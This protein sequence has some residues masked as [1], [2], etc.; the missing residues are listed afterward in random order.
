LTILAV[1]GM[2]ELSS[3]DL[4]CFLGMGKV[5]AREWEKKEKT[6]SS[7]QNIQIGGSRGIRSTYVYYTAKGSVT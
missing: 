6:E 2:R 5:S 4:I 7:S 3:V 1:I